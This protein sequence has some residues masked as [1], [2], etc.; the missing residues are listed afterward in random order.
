MFH[1]GPDD[2][3][4]YLCGSVGIAN[5]RL[6]IIDLK[7]GR[8]PIFNEDRSASIVFNGEVYNFKDLRSRLKQ[9]TFLTQ[10]DT[11]VV[12]HAY[13]EWGRDC[14]PKLN[15]MFAIAIWDERRQALLLAR[16]AMGIKPLY[17]VHTPAYFAFASEIKALLNA[18]LVSPEV[19]QA[20][21]GAY[22]GVKYVPMQQ[23]L[24]RGVHRLQ[25][26]EWLTIHMDG[27]TETGKYWSYSLTPIV[28]ARQPADY[29]HELSYLVQQAVHDQLVADVPIGAFLSGG[30]D[31]SIVV[32]E[33]A[34]QMNQQVS[35]FTID[36]DAATGEQNEA[37]Y[38]RIT[39]NYA[40]AKH[41]TVGCTTEQTLA[42]LP[43]LIYHLD[44]P[45][46]EPLITPS[47]LLAEA[48]RREVTVVL[49]G[50]GADELFAGYPRYQL[51][52]LV[53]ILQ[54]IPAPIRRAA[55]KIAA[56]CFGPQDIKTRVL[57]I[58]LDTTTIADWY[59]VFTARESNALMGS[60]SMTSQWAEQHLGFNSVYSLLE[61]LL[62]LEFRLRL[63]EYLLTRADKM[64][65]AHSIEM[66][67]PL[68][69]SRIVEFAR[70]LP[71]NLKLH[72]QTGKYILRRAFEGMIPAE[73]VNRPKLAFSA[74]FE[75]WLPEV[76]QRYLRD[77]HCAQAGLLRQT[78]IDRLLNNDPFYRGRQSE[79][80]WTLVVLEIWY[81]VFL[82]RTLQQE[83]LLDSTSTRG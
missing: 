57:K 2:Y 72:G 11:E 17:Y 27:N 30:L 23:T 41:S 78:E 60:A 71:A 18:G 66:R 32:M 70:T 25:P 83:M 3:G 58:S 13:D 38:A 67:P 19:D 42:L 74:P 8:Q 53:T 4:Q 61:N 64:T 62:T 16:D 52:S 55:L 63:P 43:R 65:M 12:L 10:S 48:A 76:C 40:G 26:G 21:L 20:S 24:F 44:E 79:K 54:M 73:I 56:R 75:S 81:R 49:T 47:Y 51:S 1:R 5:L 31:S 9:H 50:E 28:T 80:L 82:D 77:S 68:L 35:A 34:R 6:S 14:L 45:I 59:L 39:A 29:A 33:M 22:L 46:S 36:Y 15:G 37:Y 7:T 69:D